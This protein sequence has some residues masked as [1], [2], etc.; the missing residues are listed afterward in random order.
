MSTTK[1]F[2]AKCASLIAQHN[3]KV[4]WSLG[5]PDLRQ[6]ICAGSRVNT[7][8][9]CL[10]TLHSTSMCPNNNFNNKN[11]KGQF[12]PS[13]QDRY[14]RDIMYVDGNQVCNNFNQPKGCTK[15]YCRYTHA[16]KICKNSGHGK[17]MCGSTNKI[18]DSVSKVP[19]S[20]ANKLPSKQSK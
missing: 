6:I 7:C 2:S 12:N 9:V 19:V 13:G 17:F 11:L 20:M 18:A 16:C 14:G 1:C 8:N 4:D 5:D 15:P 10:S 3:T